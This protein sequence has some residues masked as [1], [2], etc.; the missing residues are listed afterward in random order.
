MIRSAGKW[1]KR[2]KLANCHDEQDDA[3]NVPK[4]KMVHLGPAQGAKTCMAR[5]GLKRGQFKK[6]YDS[7][8]NTAEVVEMI[9][10]TK[11]GMNRTK[12]GPDES[13]TKQS[14]ARVWYETYQIRS[15]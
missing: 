6:Q 1:D 12:N 15:M 13:G 3:R 5:S 10:P 4:R 8:A 7:R 9:S 11:F 14:E 2:Q